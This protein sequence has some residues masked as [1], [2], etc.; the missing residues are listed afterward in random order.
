MARRWM[1]AVLASG[2]FAGG[3]AAE[4]P[5]A[6]CH[7]SEEFQQQFT[8]PGGSPEHVVSI[9]YRLLDQDGMPLEVDLS[10]ACPSPSATPVLFT[11]SVP[12]REAG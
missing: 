5:L 12:V 7:Y 9:R 1:F 10:A 4:E 6:N 11:P 3:A 2:L 8:L